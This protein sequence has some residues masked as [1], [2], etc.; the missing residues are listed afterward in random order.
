M[1]DGDTLKVYEEFLESMVSKGSKAHSLL[2]RD[3]EDQKAGNPIHLDHCFD[4]LPVDLINFKIE[5]ESLLSRVQK[6][7]EAE[8][9]TVQTRLVASASEQVVSSLTAIPELAD[10]DFTADQFDEEEDEVEDDL[11][12]AMLDEASDPFAELVVPEPKPLEV[13]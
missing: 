11:L 3:L 12:Q 1:P 4:F 5:A 8:L 2:R 9:E 7:I 6:E 13:G 10:L